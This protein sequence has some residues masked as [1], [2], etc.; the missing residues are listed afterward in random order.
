M[1]QTEDRSKVNADLTAQREAA[2]LL[3]VDRY[4]VHVLARRAGIPTHRHPMNG[5]ARCFDAAGM[6]LLAR[7]VAAYKTN[8]E[9]VEAT[10]A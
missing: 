2:R 7:E 8:R 10:C 6:A 1:L 5:K 9:T 3:D 4:V